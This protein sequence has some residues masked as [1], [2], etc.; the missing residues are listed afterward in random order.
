M[1]KIMPFCGFDKEFDEI[2]AHAIKAVELTGKEHPNFLIIPTSAFDDYNRGTLNVYSK[3]GCS[4]DLLL[5]TH[6]CITEDIVRE[7]IERADMIYVPG[8]NLK[9]LMEMWQKSGTDRYIR[10]AYE[11]GALLFGSSAGSMCWFEEGF[12][13][14]APYD[15]KM[16]TPG[17]GLRPYC[18][19]PHFN[20]ENWK[21]FESEIKTRSISGI[22]V[23][24]GAALCFTD[25]GNFVFTSHGT[26]DCWFFDARDG[27]K[28]YSLSSHPEILAT[29]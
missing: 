5:L 28:K 13:N 22:A 9:Y 11:N 20:S 1:G 25:E 14:C 19:C 27:F 17:V 7:K 29:L 23:E 15:E 4:V 16:F 26:E 6:A 18:I 3:L 10:K 24:D 8:G 12:D 21:V 2:W